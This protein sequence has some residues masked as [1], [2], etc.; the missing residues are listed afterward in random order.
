VSQYKRLLPFERQW[1]AGVSL[2]M[3]L[4]LG[5][6]PALAVLELPLCAFRHLTGVPCPLCGG[7]RLCAA[8]AQGD[9]AAALQ[10]NPGL[11]PVLALAALHSGLLLAEALSGRELGPPRAL[12]VAWK[13][14]GGF[15]LLSWLWRVSGQF[16]GLF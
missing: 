10:L 7:T 15:L 9:V 16:L 14:A 3:P 5:L 6:A 2:L 11:L 1:R 4:A 8:L 13:L 12:A